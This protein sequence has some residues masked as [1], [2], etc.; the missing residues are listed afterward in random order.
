MQTVNHSI[1]PCTRSFPHS[2]LSEGH[3]VGQKGWYVYSKATMVFMVTVHCAGPYKSHPARLKEG[4]EDG[5]LKA[6]SPQ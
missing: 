1:L 6:G 5:E 4:D 3:T 2:T